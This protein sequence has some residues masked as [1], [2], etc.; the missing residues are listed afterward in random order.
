MKLVDELYEIYR[1]RLQGSDEDLDMITF[2]VVEQLSNNEIFSIINEMSE[3]ELHSFF[4]LYLFEALKEK[5][6]NDGMDGDWQAK[7]LY[8]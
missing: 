6:N 7:H 5:F 4:R 1:G 2:A 8:H 3:D